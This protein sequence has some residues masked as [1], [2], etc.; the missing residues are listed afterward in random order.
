MGYRHTG[1]EVSNF[2]AKTN[3]LKGRNVTVDSTGTVVYTTA[4]TRG[5]GVLNEDTLAGEACYIQTTNIDKST[6]GGPIVVGT[7]VEVGTNGKHITLADGIAIGKALSTGVTNNEFQ[8][9]IY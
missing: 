8:L 1:E 9:F 4:A 6:A 3:L 5:L 7:E 2:S